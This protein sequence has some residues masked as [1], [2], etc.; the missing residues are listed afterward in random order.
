MAIVPRANPADVTRVA[1]LPTVRVRARMPEDPLAGLAAVSREAADLIGQ[2]RDAYALKTDTVAVMSAQ[3]AIADWRDGW[4]DPNNPEG[5]TAYRGKHALQLVDTMSQDFD[6]ATGRIEMDLPSARARQKFKE[7]AANEREQVRARV[8]SYATAQNEDA[9]KGEREAFEASN[10]REMV[11]ALAS[12]DT[13]RAASVW[14]NTSAMVAANAAAYGASEAELQEHLSGIQSKVHA[15]TVDLLLTSDPMRA[16]Q[17]FSNHQS[18]MHPEDRAR[19]EARL[20]PIVQDATADVVRDVVM[21]GGQ[22]PD[23]VLGFD[24][25]PDNAGI[26]KV[27][28]YLQHVVVSAATRHGVPPHI[29]LALAQQESGFNTQAVGPPTKYGKAVGL[30]Q[31][32]PSTA[33]ALG[34][35][36]RNAEQAADAAM[37]E[38]AKQAAEK[39]WDWAIAHH[40]AGPNPQQHGPVTGRYVD[41]VKA[42]SRRWAD[43]RRKPGEPIEWAD[44][45]PAPNETEATDRVRRFIADPSLRRVALAKVREAYQIQDARQAEVEQQ[46]SDSIFAKVAGA[47]PRAP[48]AQVLTP[49][50]RA[51]V[52]QRDGLNSSINR[53]RTLSATG[54]VIEDDP[55]LVDSIARLRVADPAAFRRVPLAQYGDRL[56]GKTLLALTQDQKDVDKPEKREQWASEDTI[57]SLA[58]EDMG[59]RGGASTAERGKFRQSYYTAKRRFMEKAKREPTADEAQD[60]VNRLK[61]PFVQ[62]GFLGFGGGNRRAY[63]GGV[64]EFDVPADARARIVAIYKQAGRE[65]TDRDIRDYYTEAGG[66]IR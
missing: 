8:I 23:Q 18:A 28:A 57:L 64:A 27:N 26:P 13:E 35:N 33:K 36:P 12:G 24:G 59:L 1:P 14:S 44:M 2:T 5:V 66:V 52:A 25:P 54:Q 21:Q 49:A 10:T 48:L 62:E 41:Q 56:S 19:I 58:Y 42:K 43:A 51:F 31:F 11:N 50:E 46:A 39:G 34:I 16:Q 63:Q 15:G 3:R 37:S 47:D 4:N 32:L 17:H 60:L 30:F 38:L 45:G 40:H 22:L 29:G 9:I 65:P 7:Y 6:K 61:L 53:F 20:Q 55:V